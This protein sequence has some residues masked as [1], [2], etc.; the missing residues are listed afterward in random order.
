[1]RSTLFYIPKDVAG[2]PLFGFGLLLAVWAVACLGF[3]VWRVSR[4]GWAKEIWTELPMMGVMGV[5][6]AFV[7]PAVGDDKGLPIRGYGVMVFLGVASA[8]G[9]AVYRATR[10]GI[11]AELIYS[12]A[13]W[14][15][16][17]GIVGGRLFF[18]IQKWPQFQKDTLPA[19]IG[20]IFKYTEGGLVVYGALLGGAAAALVFLIR[21]KLPVLALGDIITPSV[22]LG[23]ALGRIGCFL[24]GCC[25][26]GTC[27][28]P[29]AVTFPQ[30]SPVYDE[31][32]ERGLLGQPPA[33]RSLPVH[34][35]QLYSSIG[36]FLITLVLIAWYPF[37]RHNGELVALMMTIYPIVRILE[38][39]IR[40]DEGA[41]LGTSLSIS[42]NVSLLIL[43]G[44]VAVWV[45]VLRQPRLQYEPA[46][47]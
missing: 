3:F 41:S 27:D 4:Y 26:G 29:W 23:L 31:Q 43:A 28:L 8:V 46:A 2:L 39:A 9:L 18:V 24:N 33:P 22:M 13:V 37:R 14:L 40:I 42:Q 11:P 12:M 44:A 34:P 25:F 7:L 15:V 5:V 19:T 38:E 6:I 1:M 30:G 10:E 20:A 36:A 47:A 45:F 17:S 21:Y 16:V 35:A 32:F